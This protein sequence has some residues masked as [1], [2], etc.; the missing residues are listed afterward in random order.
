MNIFELLKDATM[1]GIVNW[2]AT[3]NVVATPGLSVTE[4]RGYKT[5][6]NGSRL[7]I[8]VKERPKGFFKR[9]W[10]LGSYA[11]ALAI[12]ENEERTVLTNDPETIPGEQNEQ[13][14]GGCYFIQQEIEKK[15]LVTSISHEIA[16]LLYK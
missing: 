9:G 4:R 1:A 14:D 8:I 7:E 5:T 2:V 6:L 16:K 10:G 3:D 11:I 12:E 15:N 13:V